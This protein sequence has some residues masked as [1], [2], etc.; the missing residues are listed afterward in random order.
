ML[1]PFSASPSKT[2][3]K[4]IKRACDISKYLCNILDRNFRNL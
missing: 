3:E 2:D 1:H 4:H